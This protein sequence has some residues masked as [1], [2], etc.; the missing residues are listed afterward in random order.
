MIKCNIK[1]LI[2]AVSL[3]ITQT[4]AVEQ[5]LSDKFLHNG[6]Y[7]ERVREIQSKH[8]N[9]TEF[10][11]ELRPIVQEL[12]ESMKKKVSETA[13][14]N[15]NS[16]TMALFNNFCQ[17]AENEFSQKTMNLN[18]LNYLCLQMGILLNPDLKKKF[19]IFS[20]FNTFI[21]GIEVKHPWHLP[22]DEAH[23]LLQNY[24]IGQQ[25]LERAKQAETDEGPDKMPSSKNSD[26]AYTLLLNLF[27]IGDRG[28]NVYPIVADSPLY[29][30]STFLEAFAEQIT[31]VGFP[32]DE[33]CTLH[34]GLI[35]GGEHA[36][37]AWH[38]ILHIYSTA[39]SQNPRL[40]HAHIKAMAA[41]TKSLLAVIRQ[42]S[43][44]EQKKALITLFIA[45]HELVNYGENNSVLFDENTSQKAVLRGIFEHAQSRLD[46]EISVS[47]ASKEQYYRQHFKIQNE[48]KILQCHEEGNLKHIPGFSNTDFDFTGH[49]VIVSGIP[50]ENASVAFISASDNLLK[51]YNNALRFSYSIVKLLNHVPGIDDSYGRSY[52]EYNPVQANKIIAGLFRD[53]QEKYSHLF[54]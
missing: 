49:F 21:E 5:S 42:Q 53:F 13:T 52:E 33:K 6:S 7:L 43:V 11:P 51:T 22:Y 3:I 20:S 28:L 37:S 10:M 12:V 8:S 19:S 40:N 48:M 23:N 17:Y 50:S 46:K 27:K 2:F 35:G 54:S 9:T 29:G 30:I 26:E 4:Q 45:I 34:C 1:I 47:L 18:R 31:F 15:Q 38:D 14:L 24:I 25:N 16:A 36:Y 39:P 32:L 44:P 41:V